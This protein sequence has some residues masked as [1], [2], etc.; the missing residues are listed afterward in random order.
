MPVINGHVDFHGPKL[1]QIFYAKMIL[2]QVVPMLASPMGRNVRPLVHALNFRFGEVNGQI[3]GSELTLPDPNL[4][5]PS[6]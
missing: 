4:D 1:V 3:A 5:P 2:I 6:Y